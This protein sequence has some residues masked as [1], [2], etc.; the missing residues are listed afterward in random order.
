M[1]K[2]YYRNPKADQSKKDFY[3][4]RKS[5]IRLFPILIVVVVLALTVAVVMS[6]PRW[7]GKPPVVLLKKDFKALGRNPQISITV[8]D[9]GSGLKQFS[10]TLTQK[11]QDCSF[12]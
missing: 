2:D 8:Q 3:G 5:R 11:N 1:K 7:E 12:G 9:S 10:A 6:W 4:E